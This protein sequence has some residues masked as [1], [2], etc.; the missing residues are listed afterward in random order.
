[1]RE[2]DKRIL[3]VL[4][5]I[6]VALLYY[7]YIYSPQTGKIRALK[8]EKAR[9][10]GDLEKATREANRL[11]Q[12]QQERDMLSL[13]FSE[14]LE[15]LPET[16]EMGKLFEYIAS[17]SRRYGIKVISLTPGG[18]RAKE[19]YSE[20][21]FELVFT[22]RYEKVGAFLDELEQGRRVLALEKVTMEPFLERG[23]IPAGVKVQATFLTFTTQ[24]V[25]GGASQPAPPPP[26]G[27]QA[28]PKETAP[29]KGGAM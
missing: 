27:G 8:E 17:I 29:E 10:E 25:A 19:G 4:V 18:P 16:P 24:K 12:L 9:K 1:M 22:G 3:M 11:P 28:P 26:S 5:P 14:I 13:R 23:G 21:P 2:R 6:I 15:S 20:I 7:V